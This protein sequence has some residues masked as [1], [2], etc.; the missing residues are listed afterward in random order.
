[1]LREAD[2]EFN[3]DVMWNIF[4]NKP[5]YAFFKAATNDGALRPRFGL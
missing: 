4:L 5:D 1:M 3:T 2:T